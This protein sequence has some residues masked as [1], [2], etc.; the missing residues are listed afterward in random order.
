MDSNAHI[1][2]NAEDRSYFAILKKEIHNLVLSAGFTAQRTAEVDI[3][4]AEMASNLNKHAGGGEILVKLFNENDNLYVEL[5]S[6]DNGPGIADPAKMMKDGM[7]TAKTLGQGLGSMQR[8][9]DFF[10]IYSIKDWGTIVLCRLYKSA[11]PVTIRKSP[12]DVRYLVVAKPG[13]DVSGDGAAYSLTKDK[14]RLFLGDGL[15]HGLDAH[16]AVQKAIT[17]FKISKEYQPVPFLRDLHLDVRKTRGLVAATA[18]YSFPEKKWSIAGIGNIATRLQHHLLSKAYVAHNG[19]IGLNIPNTMKE[20][21]VVG[22][23]GQMIIMCSD[24]IKTRW[25]LQKYVNIFRYDLTILA[26]AIYKD[27]GRKTDDMSVLIGKVNSL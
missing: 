11:L 12:A 22:E 21:L 27:F 14:L 24:G 10:Q 23:R 15:G 2:F 26:A 17:S 5:I 16:I 9:S 1:S 6:I 25:D 8:L 4:V 19:I 18:T 7:S 13:E 3:V 20:Q